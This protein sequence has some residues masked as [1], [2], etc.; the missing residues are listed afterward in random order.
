M[1]RALSAPP[2]SRPR[3]RAC[4]NLSNVCSFSAELSGSSE[5]SRARLSVFGSS[6]ISARAGLTID[7]VKSPPLLCG[8]Q[9]D[10]PNSGLLIAELPGGSGRGDEKPSP[11]IGRA[12]REPRLTF[13]DQQFW[14]G[15]PSARSSCQRRCPAAA[16]CR[17]IRGAA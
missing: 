1:A 14:Q 4:Q 8:F 16:A 7:T 13:S 17:R 5:T 12:L 10:P 11:V 2:T 15:N 3:S 6:R 9:N